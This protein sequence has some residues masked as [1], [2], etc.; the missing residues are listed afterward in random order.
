MSALVTGVGPCYTIRV[1]RQWLH[2]KREV[3]GLN[4][5]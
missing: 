5:G 1:G 2:A 4:K 3:A